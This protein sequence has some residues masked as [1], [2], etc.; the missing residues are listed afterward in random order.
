MG[1][2]WQGLGLGLG[3]HGELEGGGGLAWDR[4]TTGIGH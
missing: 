2:S 3:Q 1:D 4:K